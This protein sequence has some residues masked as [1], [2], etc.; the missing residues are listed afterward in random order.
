MHLHT[1]QIRHKDKW[2]SN[3]CH[4][5]SISQG[6]DRSLGPREGWGLKFRPSQALTRMGPKIV[7]PGHC[8]ILPCSVTIVPS[9]CHPSLEP[10]CSFWHISRYPPLS[11]PAGVAP[12][13]CPRSQANMVDVC[14]PSSC[15]RL[16]DYPMPGPDHNGAKVAMTS[17]CSHIL[18]IYILSD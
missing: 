18:G 11:P 7:T 16:P 12:L 8:S 13:L 6:A 15:H 2:R 4:G 14:P 9:P 17:P 1:L 10:L 5:G 3:Q